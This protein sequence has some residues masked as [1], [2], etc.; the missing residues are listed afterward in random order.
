MINFN[1]QDKICNFAT[2]Y[3]FE[4]LKSININGKS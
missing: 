2:L 1:I 3:Q 4:N